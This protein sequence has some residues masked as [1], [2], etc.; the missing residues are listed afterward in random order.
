MSTVRD[1]IANRKLRS[2][3]V[4]TVIGIALVLFMLGFL[5]LLLLK[6]NELATYAKENVRFEVYLL[7]KAKEAD[8]LKLQK[9]LNTSDFAKGSKYITKE[10]ATKQQIADLGQ[11][12]TGFL[13]GYSPIPA[14]IDLNL[15]AEYIHPD[16][17]EWIV[18][19]IQ[20]NTSVKDV[21]YSPNL[22]NKI[23]ENS[24]KI[25]IIIL[26]FSG[27][28]LLI[29]IALINNTIRLAMYS[30]RFLIRSMKL[31]GATKGFI[32]KPFFKSGFVQ[33]ILGGIIA[34]GMLLGI[35]YL[36]RQSIPEFFQMKE[37]ALFLKLFS[38]IIVLGVFIA[39]FSTF[40]AVRKYMKMELDD[41]Y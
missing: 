9:S 2:S 11:D 23:Y 17:V 37:M 15:K 34:M 30:K 40:L 6:A 14:T 32:Q 13:D 24:R 4:S 33:G 5:G 22:I 41:L 21:N 36:F 8:I 12:F 10:E 38:G 28:L 20:A 27:V 1:K 31:V 35:L 29:A 3:Y 19:E 25:G 18:N 7:D 26:I 16:S 39:L